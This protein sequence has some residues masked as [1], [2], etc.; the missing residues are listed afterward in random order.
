MRYKK[1]DEIASKGEIVIYQAK[2]KQVQLEV[3]LEQETVW[4]S[5]KQISALFD[6][7]RTV[8]TKHLNNIFGSKELEKNSVCAKFAHTAQDGKVY[9]TAFYNLD[10]VISVGYRVN[11]RRATQFRIWATGVLRRHLVDGYTINEQRLKQQE[12]KLLALQRTIKLIAS[13]KDKKKLGYREAL[14]LIEVIRDYNYAL[15][16]LDDY[17]YKRLTISKTS[18]AAGFELTYETAIKAVKD[19][20]SKLGRSKFFGIERDQSFKSSI[21]AVYQTFDGKEL[22]TSVEEKAANLLYFVVKNHSFVDGNKR[23]AASI[24]LWFLENNGLLYKK[25]GSKRLADNALV[26]V[27]LMIAASDPKDREVIVILTVNLINR[28]N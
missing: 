25:D 8:I 28:N 6:V 17:D 11:S 22:Y 24:F 19:L 3:K 4:L 10:V 2:D 5:Q 1:E 20:R 7:D 9:Q 14:G 16:L 27:T 13:T 21:A 18:Q 23:I 15:D 26:A 12:V